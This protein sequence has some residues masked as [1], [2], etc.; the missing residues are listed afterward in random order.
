MRNGVIASLLVVAIL[1]SSAVGYLAG[2]GGRLVSTSVLTTTI[3]TTTTTV[4]T[5]LE[6]QGVVSGVVTVGGQVPANISLYSVTFKPSPCTGSCLENLVSIYPSGHYSALLA[7][8]NYSMG[9]GPSCKWSG[10]GT[11]FQNP[12]AVVSGQQIVVNINIASP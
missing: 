6:A 10:C 3:T 5:S 1:A 4:S 9:L 8:G 7:P 12:V 2:S 11:A